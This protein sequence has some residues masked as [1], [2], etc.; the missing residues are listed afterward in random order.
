MSKYVSLTFAQKWSSM[1]LLLLFFVG[2]FAVVTLYAVGIDRAQQSVRYRFHRGNEVIDQTIE[3]AFSSQE[4]LLRFR[5][6]LRD[7]DKLAMVTFGKNHTWPSTRSLAH[8]PKHV[9]A[10]LRT[11]RPTR[12]EELLLEY[13]RLVDNR[14]F[15]YKHWETL[16]EQVQ[17]SVSDLP[18]DATPDHIMKTELMLR[19]DLT[20]AIEDFAMQK[21]ILQELADEFVQKGD[22][23]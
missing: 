19:V 4:L 20:E 22:S 16:A 7:F 1:F 6:E 8:P 10:W 14:R 13:S 17:R 11:Y 23:Q 15:F 21:D 9:R 5:Q 2:V 12:E 3:N 18:G